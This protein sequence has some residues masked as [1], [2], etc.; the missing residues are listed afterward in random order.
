L[1]AA[2]ETFAKLHAAIGAGLVRACHDL[3]EGGLAVAAAEMAMAGEIGLDLDIAAISGPA[4][5]LARLFGE[6]PSRFLVE[7]APAQTTAFEAQMAGVALAALG[8]VREGDDL[9]LRDGAETLA[10]IGVAELKAAWQSG[11][12]PLDL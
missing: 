2:R 4:S 6:T 9:R 8:E 1:A 10:R 5:R 12:D 11:L 3:S 7:V